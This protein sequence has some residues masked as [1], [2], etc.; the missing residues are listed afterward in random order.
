[1]DPPTAYIQLTNHDSISLLNGYQN[2]EYGF[3]G[4][5]GGVVSQETTMVFFQ[6]PRI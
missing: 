5:A 1:M 6:S 3:G 4:A 2:I